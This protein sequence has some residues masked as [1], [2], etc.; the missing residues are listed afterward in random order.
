MASGFAQNIFYG[1]FMMC[2]FDIVIL[3]KGRISLMYAA[4]AAIGKGFQNRTWI[5]SPMNTCQ[6]VQYCELY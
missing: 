6:Q 5:K 2:S 3:S 4:L 1:L